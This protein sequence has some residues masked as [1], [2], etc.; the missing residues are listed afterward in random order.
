MRLNRWHVGI[1]RVVAE[2]LTMLHAWASGTPADRTALSHS[3]L[4]LAW[5]VSY[6]SVP[7]CVAQVVYFWAR[8]PA[9]KHV[10]GH[11]RP[12]KR[13]GPSPAR[14]IEQYWVLLRA[15][16]PNGPVLVYQPLTHKTSFY[17]PKMY[18]KSNS[19]PTKNLLQLTSR[20]SPVRA[21]IQ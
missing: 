14:A 18:R 19:A 2:C 13:Y 1:L 11:I 21:I 6:L 8:G 10:W 12:C 20:P 9:E 5:D 17:Q 4:N 16:W 7:G 3:L 15:L